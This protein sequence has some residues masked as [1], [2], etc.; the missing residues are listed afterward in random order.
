MFCNMLAQL[1]WSF[2]V[3]SFCRSYARFWMGKTQ[4]TKINTQISLNYI[5]VIFHTLK[6]YYAMQIFTRSRSAVQEESSNSSLQK[7]L[8]SLSVE[9]KY[10]QNVGIAPPAQ[11]TH[12]NLV[13]CK[14][15]QLSGLR[16]VKARNI[17][18][19]DFFVWFRVEFGI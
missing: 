15:S 17:S 8:H 2:L 14:I 9:W 7:G 4:M 16:I 5:D 3:I 12:R 13:A 6:T 18:G 19:N 10:V 1:Y 11:R